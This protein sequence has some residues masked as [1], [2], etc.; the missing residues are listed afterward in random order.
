M[1]SYSIVIP[2]HNRREK[3]F[4]LIESIYSI[5]HKPSEIIVVDD[6]STDG[7]EEFITRNFPEVKYFRMEHERWPGFT[8][9]YGIAK[10]KENL[11]YII[12]DDNVVDE[13]SVS[14]LLSIFENDE[15]GEYGVL[16]PVTCFFK[17]KDKIMYAGGSYNKVTSATKF[18]FAGE[19]YSKLISTSRNSNIIDVDGIP[20]AFIVRRDYAILCGLIP[21]YIPAQGED[22]YLIY[23][24]K[25]NLKKKV[26]VCL[27]ARIYHDYEMSGRFSDIRLYYTMRTKILFIKDSFSS[28][29]GVVNLFFMPAVFGY[30]A[31]LSLKSSRDYK[32]I[33]ILLRG[34]IDG[35]LGIRDRKFIDY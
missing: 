19:S 22:G 5:D 7:S 1:I 13:K 17:E 24:I 12:D 34:Y 27:T 28:V 6:A 26:G 35:L 30:W 4:H 11:V 18:K 14:P 8:I 16:G 15:A 23:S 21:K 32:G 31:M 3:L 9:S 10:S 33:K 20:N 29:R 2:T 25:K